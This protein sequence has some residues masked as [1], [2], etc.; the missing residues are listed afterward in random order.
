M[1]TNLLQTVIAP[2]ALP[3]VLPVNVITPV[4]LPVNVIAPAALPVN[5]IAQLHYLLMPPSPL[6]SQVLEGSF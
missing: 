2:A 1:P 3:A 6:Q 5:V 4:A